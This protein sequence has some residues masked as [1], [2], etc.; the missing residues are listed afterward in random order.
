MR[1]WR[2]HLDADD[3]LVTA[4]A[5]GAPGLRPP[6]PCSHRWRARW[7]GDPGG[8]LWSEGGRWW[9]AGEF[10]AAT[11]RA[12]GRLRAAG[13]E[14]GQ[15]VVWST[16]SS[17]DALVAHV[18]ALRAGLVVVPGQH[19]L[20]R[21]RA[22][23]HRDATSGPRPPWSAGPTRRD[24]VRDAA[25]GPVVVCGPDLELPD[26]DPGGLDGRVPTTRH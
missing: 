6:A 9:T 16:G 3:P 5:S 17:V 20:H 2:D 7:E 26:G 24:W 21:A 11:R 8:P 12:A 18:G 25:P 4:D 14:P 13:L 10:D 19:R 22:G 23:P 1:P 15:R